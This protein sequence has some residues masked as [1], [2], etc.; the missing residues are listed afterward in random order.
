[1]RLTLRTLLAFRDGVL[2]PA[3]A[4]LLEAKLK[5]SS[6]AQQ[7]SSRIDEAMRNRKL[8]P[9]PVDAREFGFEA[10]MVSEFLDDTISLEILPEMER[11]CLDN[12]ILLGEIGSCHQILSRALSVPMPIAS[13]L[14]DR[15][16]QLP[17][18]HPGAANAKSSKRSLDNAKN[19]RFDAPAQLV[20]RS[21]SMEDSSADSSALPPTRMSSRPS[22][23]LRGTG[24]EL[25]DRLGRQVPEYLIGSDRGKWRRAIMA[26]AVVTTLVLV[27][28]MAVGPL[29][30]I[31]AL[32]QSPDNAK[33]DIDIAN[34]NP[35]IPKANPNSLDSSIGKN[36]GSDEPSDELESGIMESTVAPPMPT[37]TAASES[38]AE[39]E[40]SNPPANADAATRNMDLGDSKSA[41]NPAP[42]LPGI[43]D[44]LKSQSATKPSLGSGTMQWLPD[45]KPSSESLVFLN[46]ADNP[47]SWRR[48]IPGDKAQIGQRVVIPPAQRTE[49]R[50][51]PGIRW[52]C[53]GENDLE[54][55]S[56]GQVPTVTLNAGRA[57]IFATPDATAITVRC[58]ENHLT[59]QFATADAS[60][61][62]EVINAWMPCS[63]EDL[64]NRTMRFQTQV[65]L[66]GVQGSLTCSSS[67]GGPSTPHGVI[68]V[69]EF[70]EW[71]A[72]NVSDKQKLSEVPWWLQSSFE[73]AIDQ[74][75]A[76]DMQRALSGIEPAKLD[77]ELASLISHRRSETA[78]LAART[79][80]MLGQ[81]DGIFQSNGLLNRKEMHAHWT[82][83]LSQ[84]PQSL[85]RADHRKNFLESLRT[86]AAERES[87]LFALLIPRSQSQLIDGADK[88]LVESLA[89][90]S[91]E[92]RVLAIF[93]LT[94]IT[95]KSLGYQPDRNNVEAMQQWQKLLS[96]AEIRY[97][98]SKTPSTDKN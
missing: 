66:M 82:S 83:I 15:V 4:A 8:A 92:E 57:L 28:A 50:I 24:I 1:M 52:M 27:G 51:E 36:S 67:Q 14:R 62:L 80:M 46:E 96:K 75:A 59:I 53:A 93:Q 89:S 47:G 90:Q 79:R 21:S 40:K 20:N 97:P 6:T 87:A 73:R 9:I 19:L 16:L 78:A 48:M 34:V 58:Q 13:S 91:L 69:G 65:R 70:L 71:K 37:L 2:D 61:A 17:Q 85:C 11:K 86:D 45:S 60:C 74:L 22:V 26:V 44:S 49:I 10:N 30:R 5:Q 35:P 94:K 33:V 56:A 95:G 88:L 55:T 54:L 38:K 25:D 32:L 41:T 72:S 84:I 77:A 43:I 12:G 23:P 68:E 39:S 7:I 42:P 31:I 63:E 18:Q 3:D 64:E 81:Y 29:D 76:S 98:E